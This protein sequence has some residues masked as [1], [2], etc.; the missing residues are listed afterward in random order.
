MLKLHVIVALRVYEKK[1][2]GDIIYYLVF[3]FYVVFGDNISS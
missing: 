2:S 3:A 1:N